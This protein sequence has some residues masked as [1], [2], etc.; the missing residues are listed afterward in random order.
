MSFFK[1]SIQAL[2]V[3]RVFSL[4]WFPV[5]EVGIFVL[6]SCEQWNFYL[7]MPSDHLKPTL[8][9]AR[10]FFAYIIIICFFMNML[11]VSPYHI[12]IR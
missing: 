5:I 10:F 1:E 12:L 4:F 2:Q 11:L 3:Q 7:S 6:L 8:P 9:L